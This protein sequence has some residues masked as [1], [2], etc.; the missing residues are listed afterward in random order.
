MWP[1]PMQFEKSNYGIEGRRFGALDK[2]SN[3]CSWEDLE[4]LRSSPLM[5]LEGCLASPRCSIIE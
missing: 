2:S 5:E 3:D 1:R 4:A